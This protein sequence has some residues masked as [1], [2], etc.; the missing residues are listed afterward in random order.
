M[1]PAALMRW[2]FLFRPILVKRDGW[3]EGSQLERSAHNSQTALLS[4]KQFGNGSRMKDGGTAAMLVGRITTLSSNQLLAFVP[5]FALTACAPDLSTSTAA[6]ATGVAAI[7]SSSQSI[8]QTYSDSRQQNYIARG[9]VHHQA[10]RPSLQCAQGDPTQCYLI[11]PVEEDAEKALADKVRLGLA[12][13]ETD[14][15]YVPT[16]NRAISESFPGATP[17]EVVSK[18]NVPDACL[19]QVS[20]HL[21]DTTKAAK[22]SP[23]DTTKAAKPSPVDEAAIVRALDDYA[24]A[25]V[26]VTR[27]SDVDDYK[28][29]ATK[30]GTAVGTLASTIG[31][32]A[33]GAGAAIGPVATAVV[34]IGTDVYVTILQQK[35]YEALKTAVLAACVPVHNLAYAEGIVLQ[36][37][38]AVGTRY[39]QYVANVTITEKGL[40]PA[41][42]Q[43]LLPLQM[44]ATA[45]LRAGTVDDASGP[46]K[47]LA[48]S[49]NDL[50]TAVLSGKGEPLA[51]L[52]AAG[53][54][55]A[56]AKALQ[57]ATGKKAA[58]T[59][60]AAK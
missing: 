17:I 44:A 35:R 53:T 23:D 33:G 48:Q 19:S 41:D 4:D 50:V 7:K 14:P 16:T 26:A 27:K 51:F 47:K 8:A 10:L 22:P 34:K 42:R 11:D 40:T 32:A 29:A 30:L 49:H 46:A 43:Q 52:E 20:A 9:I 58:T 55:A 57:E 12:R 1:G 18:I 37:H 21:D 28:V 60:P 15:N 54:F 2:A 39:L 5:L 13:P 59:S 6:I 31:T 45:K 24:Q 3:H 36:A 25:L 38:N 56:D